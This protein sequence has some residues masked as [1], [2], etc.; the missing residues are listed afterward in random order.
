MLGFSSGMGIGNCRLA[1]NPDNV[2]CY[3]ILRE[4]PIILVFGFLSSPAK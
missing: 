3:E 2:V 1:S 4:L